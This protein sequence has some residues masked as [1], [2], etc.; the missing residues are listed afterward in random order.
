MSK[1]ARLTTS[2]EMGATRSFLIE[3]DLGYNPPGNEL[4]Y[5]NWANVLKS[6]VFA[7]C[8]TL[9]STIHSG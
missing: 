9:Y 4:G 8:A 7:K 1:T 6:G 5:P 2:P 3:F